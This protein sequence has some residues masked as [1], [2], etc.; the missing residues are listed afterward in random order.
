[1]KLVIQFQNYFVAGSKTYT[2]TME[3]ESEETEDEADFLR[4]WGIVSEVHTAIF[5]NILHCQLSSADCT[6]V[7]NKIRDIGSEQL[8]VA[9]NVE[10][11]GHYNDCDILV[12]YLLLSRGCKQIPQPTAGWGNTPVT[13][14]TL[15]DDIE[16]IW[17]AKTY[18][19]GRRHE[20]S[21]EKGKYKDLEKEAFGICKRMDQALV[22]F[23]IIYSPFPSFFAMLTTFI[24]KAMDS[25]TKKG[26]MKEIDDIAQM[27]IDIA[28]EKE[29]FAKMCKIVLDLNPMILQDILDEQLPWA[30]CPRE[31]A[32]L[33]PRPLSRDQLKIA[34]DVPVNGYK[35][36]D[37]SLMYTFLRN[38]CKKIPPPTPKWDR[39]PTGFGIGDDIERIRRTRNTFGHARCATLNT[40]DFNTLIQE[41]R[42]I[43]QRFDTSPSH[44]Q[45]TKLQRVVYCT[46]VSEIENKSLDMA[47][48]ERYA[49]RLREINESEKNVTDA[50]YGL[51]YEARDRF[52]QT[53]K[54]L[55]Q[56]NK[57][58]DK[59]NKILDDMKGTQFC[60]SF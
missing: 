15:G 60:F 19:L 35:N 23:N 33:C 45:Y 2:F 50:V 12:M 37:T 5:R 17:Q 6:D 42:C 40:Q 58:V 27:E 52:E 26:F 55:D 51:R 11:V 44:S 57:K 13:G 41:T 22:R 49:K 3:E 14:S 32:K 21:V 48:Q 10:A 36:C 18:I 25:V 20:R 8:R 46:I 53:D 16:R 56:T 59:T 43:C 4:A 7:A 31:A 38:A 24:G 30:D 39:P 47:Q 1:M 29:N 34:N 54:K 9:R 28:K